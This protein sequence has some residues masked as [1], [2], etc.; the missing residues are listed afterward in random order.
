MDRLTT[1]LN[2]LPDTFTHIEYKH[3]IGFRC[4]IDKMEANDLIYPIKRISGVIVFKKGNKPEG[5]KREDIVHNKQQKLKS[6]PKIDREC[7]RQMSKEYNKLY[8]D[9][10]LQDPT[11]NWDKH[12][13]LHYERIYGRKCL[14]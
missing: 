12:R 4:N 11:Y 5:Y 7:A 1:I 9:T 14:L 6:R 8:A 3:I 2:K 10:N 13:G